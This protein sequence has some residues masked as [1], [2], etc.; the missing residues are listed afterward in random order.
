MS[1]TTGYNSTFAIGGISCSAD[2]FVVTESS[3]LSI[4]IC[5]ETPPIANLQNVIAN[6]KKTTTNKIN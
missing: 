1:K 3:V 2:R 4:N 5:A 6:A